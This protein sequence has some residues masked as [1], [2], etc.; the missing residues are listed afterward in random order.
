MNLKKIWS[1]REQILEGIKNSVFKKEDVE[2]IAEQRL[3]ICN[4]CPNL[5][6]VGSKCELPG[7]QPC[8]GL[9]GCKLSYK[10]RSLSSSCPENKWDAYLTQDEEDNLTL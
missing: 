2:V 7:S 5:D 4:H 9:C 8:C 3:G 10:V 1:N 6:T